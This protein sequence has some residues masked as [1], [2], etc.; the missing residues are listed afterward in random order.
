MGD[1]GQRVG[2]SRKLARQAAGLANQ[3]CEAR[4]HAA[5]LRRSL[6]RHAPQPL[7]RHRRH[8]RWQ[9]LRRPVQRARPLRRRRGGSFPGSCRRLRRLSRGRR[10]LCDGLR[11]LRLAELRR[12]L[13]SL[14]WHRHRRRRCRRGCFCSS[15]CCCILRFLLA[16]HLR[17]KCS[18]G[19]RGCCCGC[20]CARGL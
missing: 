1:A 2:S 6:I 9:Q 14:L 3:R 10:L 17:C 19:R 11:R 15:C 12:L 18:A 13:R 4:A 16:L 5:G 8:R 7:L 20:R